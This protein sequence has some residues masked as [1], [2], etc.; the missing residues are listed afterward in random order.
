MVGMSISQAA[1]IAAPSTG[2]GQG[3]GWGRSKGFFARGQERRAGG[4]RFGK[5]F[6]S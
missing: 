2:S 6:L 3:C 1:F 5:R 4:L